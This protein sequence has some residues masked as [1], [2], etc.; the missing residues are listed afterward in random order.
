MVIEHEIEEKKR[1]LYWRN[2]QA[3]SQ[4][5]NEDSECAEKEIEEKKIIEKEPIMSSNLTNKMSFNR[6]L[7]SYS[8]GQLGE[9][10]ITRLITENFKQFEVI[11][12]HVGDI[13]LANNP[14]RY[15]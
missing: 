15:Q 13:H 3:K 2:N 8:L 5:K 9:E 10:H 11:S 4:E 6:T 7:S 1:K 12:A 14:N